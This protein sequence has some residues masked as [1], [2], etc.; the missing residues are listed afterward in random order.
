MPKLGLKTGLRL[1]GGLKLARLLEMREEEFAK[2]ARELEKKPAFERLQRAG[3]LSR[4]PF[5]KAYFAA[6]RWAGW[7]LQPASEGLG[8]L[9][10]ADSDVVRLLRRIGRGRFESAFLR[11]E[12]SD[13][14]RA[15]RCGIT[16]AEAKRLRELL[17][18]LYIKEQFET[19]APPPAKV[20]SAV[21]G[22]A[23]DGGTPVLKFFHREVWKGEYAV[24]EQRLKAL[25][26]SAE[27][28]EAR[29]LSRFAQRVGFLG[30]RQTTLYKA[31]QALIQA[32]AGWLTTGDP[33]KRQPLTQRSLATALGV[34]PSAI[35]RLL[36]NKSLELPWGTEAPMK[37]LVPSGKAVSR[38]RV[39]ELARKRPELSDEELRQVLA[40]E[41][42][43]HLSRRSVAQYRQDLGLGPRRPRRG[44]A[45][46]R[47]QGMVSRRRRGP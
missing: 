10:D 31:L 22:I 32:Q 13:Q 16:P 45:A 39:G 5:P 15:R 20:F 3:V 46:A 18:R 12:A 24:D 7:N 14:E 28:G 29:R 34:D 1:Y 44:I 37:A 26:A 42:Q 23:L 9:L 33:L 25:L 19:Q 36:S 27:P 35:N 43:I 11:N 6:R 38:E 41:F 21:A 47:E 40:A 17:D 2:L 4:R 8:E 30:R